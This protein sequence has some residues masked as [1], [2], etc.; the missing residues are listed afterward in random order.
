MI[1]VII[2]RLVELF[3]DQRNNYVSD[4]SERACKSFEQYHY[5]CGLIQ[6]LAIAERIANDLR[7]DM[8]KEADE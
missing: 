3:A 8:E 2:K 7:T 5:L 1:D 6:G 4:V